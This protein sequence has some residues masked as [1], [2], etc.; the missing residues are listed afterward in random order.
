MHRQFFFDPP[1]KTAKV[2]KM[3]GSRSGELVDDK[4]ASLRAL[5]E[6][7]GLVVDVAG[8]ISASML[9]SPRADV[10]R[11]LAGLGRHPSLVSDLNAGTLLPSSFLTLDDDAL[12]S[13]AVAD[14]RQRKCQ[15]ADETFIRMECPECG[16][17]GRGTTF[18][19]A[20]GAKPMMGRAQIVLR[21]Q[22]V[23]CGHVWIADDR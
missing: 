14:A 21:G 1:G 10:R 8:E 12:A 4:M 18:L 23:E 19:S 9:D 11:L 15:D 22:C 3:D 5:F 16:A 6:A 2:C 17:D 13:R 7:K 20:A